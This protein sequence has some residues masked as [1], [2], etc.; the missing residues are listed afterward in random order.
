MSNREHKN[1]QDSTMHLIN[2]SIV[3]DSD[4]PSIRDGH[5]F[6]APRW[7]RIVSQGLNLGTQPPLRF[8]REFFQLPER[9]G[10]ELNR[11]GHNRRRSYSLRS[12]LIFSQGIVR[13]SF[14]AS[15]A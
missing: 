6:L 4:P 8:A 13:G 10:L 15:R 9:K 3:A 12:F 2:N 11:I 7:E 1:Q 5:H 14:K